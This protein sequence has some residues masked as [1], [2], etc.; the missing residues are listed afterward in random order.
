MT[1]ITPVPSNDLDLNL[2]SPLTDEIGLSIEELGRLEKT[3]EYISGDKKYR[4]SLLWSSKLTAHLI[5]IINNISNTLIGYTFQ[6]IE[7]QYYPCKM[8]SPYLEDDYAADEELIEELLELID[9]KAG[10]QNAFAV[11]ESGGLYLQTK[12]EDEGFILEYQAISIDFHFKVPEML[13]LD[14]VKKAFL[15]FN[16]GDDKWSCC[17][18][19]EHINIKQ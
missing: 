8:I 9:R 1:A 11:I 12:R 2:L 3:N 7:A 13:S 15:S 10:G 5:V 6:D 14:D 4:H 16:S 17:L 19:W 18:E